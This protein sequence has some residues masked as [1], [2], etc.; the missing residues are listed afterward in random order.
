MPIGDADKR[1]AVATPRDHA[2]FAAIAAAETA[3]EEA[4]FARAA[5]TPPGERMLAGA[6]LSAVFPL[7]P[8][9][10]AELDARVDGE[11]E[12][13]RRRIALGLGKKVPA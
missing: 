4:R 7:T 9:V 11:M 1:P 10:L 12:I 5:T 6:R 2:H 13:A 3:E 8:A